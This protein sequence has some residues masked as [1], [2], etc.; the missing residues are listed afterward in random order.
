[1]GAVVSTIFDSDISR[2][3]HA[4]KMWFTYIRLI[5]SRRDVGGWRCLTCWEILL[6]GCRCDSQTLTD[7]KYFFVTH[8]KVGRASLFKTKLVIFSALEQH[9]TWRN[10]AKLRWLKCTSFLKHESN[11]PLKFLCILPSLFTLSRGAYCSTWKCLNKLPTNIPPRHPKSSGLM[12]CLIKKKTK[13]QTFWQISF[14]TWLEILLSELQNIPFSLLHRGTGGI[15]VT[16]L[17]PAD[18]KFH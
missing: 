8:L 2:V 10:L 17:W 11:S 9:H 7:H 14:P 1:M 12:L 6:L 4:F 3:R 16:F 13:K 15:D 5:Y 18:L